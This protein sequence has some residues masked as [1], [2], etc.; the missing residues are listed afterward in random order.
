[1]SYKKFFKVFEDNKKEYK[2]DIK[3]GDV[4][5]TNFGIYILFYATKS[6]ANLGLPTKANDWFLYNLEKRTIERVNSYNN[7]LIK[8]EGG[9]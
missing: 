4:F 5:K 6:F 7:F 8:K 3:N 9:I 1:M 2:N